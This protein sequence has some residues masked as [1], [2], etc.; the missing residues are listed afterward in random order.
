MKIE[1][2]SQV[3]TAL[4]LQ[5]SEDR[6][7]LFLLVQ[8][9]LSHVAD[10]KSDPKEG[11]QKVGKNDQYLLKI[12]HFRSQNKWKSNCQWRKAVKL[13]P[14]VNLRELIILPR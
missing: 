11:F 8:A 12:T 13:S 4:S 10:F 6:Y 14:K 2:S 9:L 7:L 1:S 3:E 5:G